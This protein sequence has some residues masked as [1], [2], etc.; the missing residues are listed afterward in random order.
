MSIRFFLQLHLID[1]G[2]VSGKIH[3]ILFLTVSSVRLPADD[4]PMGINNEIRH[5]VMNIISLS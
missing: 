5:R 2:S 3:I 4:N 1:F